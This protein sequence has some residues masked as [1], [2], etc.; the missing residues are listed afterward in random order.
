M[1]YI[2][3]VEERVHTEHSSQQWVR[4]QGPQKKSLG[5]WG[6]KVYWKRERHIHSFSSQL[7]QC[8][9]ISSQGG[10][11]CQR[12]VPK[13]WNVGSGD[14]VVDSSPVPMLSSCFLWSL[15]IPGWLKDFVFRDTKGTACSQC[16][17]FCDVYSISSHL[18]TRKRSLRG[19]GKVGQR[20]TQEGNRRKG[21]KQVSKSEQ[22]R[23]SRGGRQARN[24]SQRQTRKMEERRTKQTE[25][26]IREAQTAI[27]KRG[28]AVEEMKTNGPDSTR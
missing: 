20:H 1:W 9:L 2:G 28:N 18:P 16:N 17:Y 12:W 10:S 7:T 15:G 3:T 8:L 25:A 4:E 13:F 27:Q 14:P 26:R 5:K 11:G 21:Q 23:Q 19:E 22:R 6:R 24:W